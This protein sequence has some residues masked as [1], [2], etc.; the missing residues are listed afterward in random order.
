[1]ADEAQVA[2]LKEGPQ[3]WN[4]WRADQPDATV[5]LSNGAL[6]GL[7]LTGAD[8]LGADLQRAD[9]R[10]AVLKG[11][12]LAGAR[13]EGANLFKAILDETDLSNTSLLGAQ[14]IHCAQLQAAHHWQLA[15]RDDDLA[16]GATIP[17]G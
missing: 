17:A 7:D 5:D 9:L 8:L 14:F 11:A 10:G 2:L 6:R 3:V 12:N 16:C 4:A 15:Y 13:L 1:M